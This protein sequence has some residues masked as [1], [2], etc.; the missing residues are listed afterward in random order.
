MKVENFKKALAK[1]AEVS[2]ELIEERF[3]PEFAGVKTLVEL[4]EDNS[5]ISN[6]INCF[7]DWEET[8]EGW[9]FWKDLK[10]V[11]RSIDDGFVE[12][13]VE[14]KNDILF[15]VGVK[16]EFR[17]EPGWAKFL[18]HIPEA[19]EDE[20]LVF[21]CY[22]GSTHVTCEDGKKFIDSIGETDV[23]PKEYKE[24]E[25]YEYWINVYHRFT[26]QGYTSE[27]EADEADEYMSDERIDCVCIKR[28][29]P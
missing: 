19:K 16:Y 20:R 4:I 3:D 29:N 5:C 28:C 7:C 22:D 8:K 14:P 18:L 2:Y 25:P 15:K 17:D 11:L 21:V 12:N 9:T 27:T 24:P 10:K 13:S 23:L 1:R 6:I 26:S